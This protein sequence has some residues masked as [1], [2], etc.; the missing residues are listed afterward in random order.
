MSKSHKDK[1]KGSDSSSAKQDNGNITQ[2]FTTAGGGIFGLMSKNK[3]N[4]S[5]KSSAG[6]SIIDKMFDMLDS[7]K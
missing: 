2:A 3:N 4:Y 1:S 5:K 6:N 7:E